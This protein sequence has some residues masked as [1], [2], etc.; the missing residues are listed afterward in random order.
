[1]NYIQNYKVMLQDEKSQ[2]FSS[3]AAYKHLLFHWYL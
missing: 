1:M 2:F 3:E